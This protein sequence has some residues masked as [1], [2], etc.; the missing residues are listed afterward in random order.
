M[1]LKEEKTSED[2]ENSSSSSNLH[3]EVLLWVFCRC[4][5]R[6]NIRFVF[7]LNFL[8]CTFV[9]LLFRFLIATPLL[10]TRFRRNASCKFRRC[11][12]AWSLFVDY[13]D[14]YQSSPR[15]RS[16]DSRRRVGE[17]FLSVLTES[18]DE[19]FALEQGCSRRNNNRIVERNWNHWSKE[20]K[21]TNKANFECV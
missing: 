13:D 15:T 3:S 5:S 16:L 2:T 18:N 9:F 8:I 20:E 6:K 17:L 11:Y 4:N 14:K 10:H 19:I 21:I 7:F 1:H 12:N